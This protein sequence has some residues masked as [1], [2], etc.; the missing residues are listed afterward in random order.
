MRAVAGIVERTEDLTR[1]TSALGE[2]RKRGEGK[3]VLLAGE[4]GAGKTTLLRCFCE[5]QGDARVMWGA[6]E[7]L[8]TSRPLS[9]LIDVAEDVG[10]ELRR[11]IDTDPRPHEL[12]TALMDELR[13]RRP[14]VLILEDVHWAD[15]A[16]LD[17]VMLVGRRVATVPSLVVASFREETLERSQQLQLVL[18]EL[19]GYSS[20][21]TLAPLSLAAVRELASSSEVDAR[22]LHDRTGGNPFFVTE[23]LEAGGEA[24]PATVRD[25]VFAR[26]AV[27]SREARRLLDILSIVPGELPTWLLERLAGS[28]TE[29]LEE[30]LA[31]GVLA[32][33]SGQVRFRHELARL[34][35]EGALAPTR[36]AEL[37]GVALAVL[38]SRPEHALD[39]ARLAYH[40]EAAGAVEE[41]LR[42]APLAG[43]RA[44]RVG[45]HW[46]AGEQYARALRCAS[47]MRPKDRIE[48]L[49][50][51]VEECW[52]TEQF[53]IAIE[54]EQEVLRYARVLG[55]R[56]AEGDALRTLSRLHFFVGAVRD[57][58][59][60][61]TQ[62]VDLLEQLEPGH[63]LAM[64]YGNLSQRRSVTWDIPQTLEWGDRTLALADRLH[65]TEA[66]VYALTNIGT[67]LCQVGDTA[68]F[69]RLERALQLAQEH[70]LEDYGGRALHLLAICALRLRRL[71]QVEAWLERGFAY[72]DEHG[73]DAWRLFLMSWRARL[74]LE[75]GNW[76][77]ARES[78]DGVLRDYR[79]AVFPRSLAVSTLAL[80][81]A[82]QGD[83]GGSRVLSDERAATLA[84]GEL[85][86]IAHLALARTEIAWLNGAPSDAVVQETDAAFALAA[87]AKAP[88]ELGALACWRRR[89]GIVE[90][91]PNA[92]AEP[93]ALSLVGET[94]RASDAWRRLGCPY[95]AALALADADD[96]QTLRCAHAELQ[97]LG[98]R[99]AA[100]IV[101]RR[102]RRRGVRDVPRGP[103]ARTRE[104]SA[105]LTPRELEVVALLA[106]GLRNAQIAERLVVSEKTVD[107]HVSAILRKLQVQTRGEAGAKATELGLVGGG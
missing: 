57:G 40:A 76:A 105:G 87:R 62:A 16:T 83:H 9:P 81:D 44:A 50:R 30:C 32:A 64:A 70:R 75:R 37:H 35:I 1:L 41:V 72:C 82:R 17:V 88:W 46:E 12:A 6:C 51:Q 68:G 36:R 27:L 80:V 100:A 13:R 14:T 98:A 86:R 3:L 15:E 5:A 77:Q 94:Q 24:L 69:E 90:E 45:A 39:P 47:D 7:P 107:H 21:W 11:L 10:G 92:V 25:A 28:A 29:H 99:P 61:A 38:R 2:V 73:L 19:A 106:R 33:G 101:A 4:A 102:L 66:T 84:T 59:A 71:D 52:L 23:V 58:E 74:E 97:E 20:R 91:V 89:S 48:L 63:E 22:E 49:R 93:Y 95:E 79:S 78:A 26:T 31:A 103:R 85:D 18:G 65:D 43:E 60:C 104:N 55:D 34:A 96:E 53:D 54:L 42:W 56:L 8:L 67:A